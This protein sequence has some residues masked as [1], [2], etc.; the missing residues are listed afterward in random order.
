MAHFKLKVRKRR[1]TGLRQE[2]TSSGLFM[3][4]T[5]CRRWPPMNYNLL[6]PQSRMLCLC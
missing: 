5:L 6:F 2:S 1:V 3:F 4:T